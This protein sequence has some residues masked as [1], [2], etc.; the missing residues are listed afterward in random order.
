LARDEAVR[1]LELTLEAIV[2]SYSEYI[3]YNS[4]TTQS[5]RGELLYTLL[6]FLRL[7]ASYDRVAWNLK[8]VVLAH[9][10]LVRNGRIEAAELWCQAV[11]QR[12]A[13]VAD[14]HLARLET[15]VRQY[16]M[17]LPSVA[18]RLGERFVRPLAID[19]LCALVGP[20][21]EERRGDQPGG[22][23]DVLEEE[24]AHFT[25]EPSGVGFDVP[26][27][28]EALQTEVDRTRSRGVE[29]DELADPFPT[30]PQARL[31]RE[32]VERQ[33]DGWQED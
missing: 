19:R 26:L 32:E 2:E 11:A 30:I 16:G 1:W 7:E 3:D 8:P 18:D 13:Q 21:V 14:D 12:S 4:T 24:V 33:I 10:V 31:C 5:D 17:R 28:L 23:F 15:M 29:E 27:W 25:A 20:A 22:C 9:E 6:D